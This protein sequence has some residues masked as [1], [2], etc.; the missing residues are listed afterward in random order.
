M[1][2]VCESLSCILATSQSATTTYISIQQQCNT[3]LDNCFLLT[4]SYM[5]FRTIIHQPTP[6]KIHQMS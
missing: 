1:Q 5:Y 4:V 6:K 2:S 3:I